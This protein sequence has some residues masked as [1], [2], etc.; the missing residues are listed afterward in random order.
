MTNAIAVQ[1]VPNEDGSFG[2]M[3]CLRADAFVVLYNE[4]PQ[5][6]VILLADDAR[7]LVEKI[8]QCVV[9]LESLERPLG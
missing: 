7:W 8:Q 1:V 3:L 6:G 5:P 4:S 2:I 9:E